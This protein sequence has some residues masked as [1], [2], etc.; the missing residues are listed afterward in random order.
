MKLTVPSTH[1]D[2][3]RSPAAQQGSRSYLLKGGIAW[4]TAKAKS[5]LESALATMTTD[6]ACSIF[7][8]CTNNWI[9]YQISLTVVE[10]AF[11]EPINQY[12]GIFRLKH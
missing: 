3:A 7:Q 4:W 5:L 11:L 8:S 1:T 9:S 10:S 12:P 6:F 2:M